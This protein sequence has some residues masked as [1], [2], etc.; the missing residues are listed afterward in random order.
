V[1]VHGLATMTGKWQKSFCSNLTQ[2]ERIYP[3]FR[4]H[5]MGAVLSEKFILSKKRQAISGLLKSRYRISALIV[6]LEGDSWF[7]FFKLV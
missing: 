1:L 2:I 6:L 3:G 7:C 5:S 4:L